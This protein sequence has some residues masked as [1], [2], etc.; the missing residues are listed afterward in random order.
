[1]WL[2]PYGTL[3]A[4]NGTIQGYAGNAG[5]QANGDGRYRFFQSLTGISGSG[6]L[7][8]RIANTTPYISCTLNGTAL[9][10]TQ[11]PS[12]LMSSLITLMKTSYRIGVTGGTFPHSSINDYPSQY[13]SGATYSNLSVTEV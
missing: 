5:I 12:G 3:G 13:F 10:C 11:P 7:A 1:M 8:F 4:A 9:T 6:T 2:S